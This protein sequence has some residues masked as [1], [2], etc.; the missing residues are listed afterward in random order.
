M[1]KVSVKV[2]FD[3]EHTK[4]FE[5]VTSCAITNNNKFLVISYRKVTLTDNDTLCETNYS[6]AVEL[7]KI[8]SYEIIQIK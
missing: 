5:N 8:L 4:T 1:N 3:L 7:D 2:N 6:F